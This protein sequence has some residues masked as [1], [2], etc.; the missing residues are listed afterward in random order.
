EAVG[1]RRYT[2]HTRARAMTLSTPVRVRLPNSMSGW[3]VISAWN[4]GVNCPG[5]H[6]GHSEQPSPE[7]VRRTAPPV[8]MMPIWAT[9]FATARPQVSR[10]TRDSRAAEDGGAVA[11][12]GGC[13]L[14]DT[15]LA[16]V[17]VP[18][19]RRRRW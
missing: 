15:H 2:A 1:S 11:A 5:S 3:N 19:G 14:A 13:G 9:R 7:P 8:T 4:C 16:Y 10:S 18:P 6:I 12:V 17:E